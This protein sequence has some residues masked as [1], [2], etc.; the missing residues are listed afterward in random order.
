MNTEYYYINELIGKRYDVINEMSPVSIRP[1][2]TSDL[3][4]SSKK[5]GLQWDILPV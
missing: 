5:N 1:T 3:K 2:G 4:G